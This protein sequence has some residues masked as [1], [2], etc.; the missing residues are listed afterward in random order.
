M[1]TATLDTRILKVTD[2]CDKCGAQA[3]VQGTMPSGFSL[4]FCN[5][6]ANSKGRTGISNL[7]ALREQGATI[8]DESAFINKS[9]SPS[10][11]N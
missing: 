9:P 6:H 7:E 8:I 10:A 1:S 3:F 2:R 5:H 11:S 4:Y